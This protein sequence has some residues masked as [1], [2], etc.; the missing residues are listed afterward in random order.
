MPHHVVR[1]A[2]AP[3][4][5]QRKRVLALQP[6]Q[7]QCLA[8]AHLARR[9]R[10]AWRTAHGVQ[11]I[12]GVA[13]GQLLTVNHRDAGGRG[14]RVLL[15]QGGRDGDR[16]QHLGSGGRC[17]GT[18]LPLDLSLGLHCAAQGHGG[19]CQCGALRGAR[20]NLEGVCLGHFLP[21]ISVSC[22]TTG[23]CW[24]RAKCLCPA[25]SENTLPGGMGLSAASSNLSPKPS[26][27]VPLMTVT[28]R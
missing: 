16:W 2:D 11:Q 21:P 18:L 13:G 28:R 26:S 3:P 10:E 5:D 27:S 8:P 7:G 15:V 4:I 6:A 12:G 1:G 17:C 25:C 22:S 20:G 9:E 24:V 19:Q 14:A 23:S